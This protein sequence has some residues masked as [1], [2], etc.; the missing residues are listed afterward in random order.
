[1]SIAAETIRVAQESIQDAI[2]AARGI[3]TESIRDAALKALDAASTAIGIATAKTATITVDDDGVTVK[4]PSGESRWYAPHM[5]EN[6][7]GL[8]PFA[9]VVDDRT[10]A[11]PRL[12]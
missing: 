7:K 11:A 1:M 10:P 6:L 4:D 12:Q 8:Y 9:T 2:E 3:E 5:L